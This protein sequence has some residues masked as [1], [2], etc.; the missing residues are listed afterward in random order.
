MLWHLKKCSRNRNGLIPSKAHAVE[1]K[2]VSHMLDCRAWPDSCTDFP[3][4]TRCEQLLIFDS[5]MLMPPI[6][7]TPIDLPSRERKMELQPIE[8]I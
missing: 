1:R 8:Y 4:C 7:T 2:P 5:P 6:H 3:G